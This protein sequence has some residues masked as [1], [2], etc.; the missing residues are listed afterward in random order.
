MAMPMQTFVAGAEMMSTGTCNQPIPP[1]IDNGT[2]VRLA[3]IASAPRTDR[4]TSHAITTNNKFSQNNPVTRL[5]ATSFA[6]RPLQIVNATHVV[7]FESLFV[8]DRTK[9]VEQIN[10]IV[11]P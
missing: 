9:L 10:Q 5:S 1:N 7:S 6:K 11:R 4:A 2:R 3:I 8:V